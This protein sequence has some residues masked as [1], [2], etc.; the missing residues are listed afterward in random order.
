[1]RDRRPVPGDPAA[2]AI[3]TAGLFMI[4]TAVFALAVGLGAFAGGNAAVA[5]AAAGLALATF[6][7]SLVCFSVDSRR[8]AEAQ[9]IT[10]AER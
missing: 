4:L 6:C 10:V 9:P 5:I 1:M 8:Y 2:E 7:G 3:S